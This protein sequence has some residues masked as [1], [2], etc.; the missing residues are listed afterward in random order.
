MSQTLFLNLAALASLVPASLLPF[1]DGGRRDRLFWLLLA[2]AIIGSIGWTA[3]QVAETWNTSLS[4]DLWVGISASLVLFAI[5]AGLN[6]HAWRLTPLLLPYMGLLGLLALVFQSPERT[7]SGLAPA[8][9]VI[10]HIISSVAT[11]GFLTLAA[12]AALAAFLQA[13]S[14][15]LKRPNSLTRS[16]P[17]LADSERLSEVLLAASE[18]VL[19]LGIASGMAMEYLETGNALIL[20]HKNILSLLAFLVIGVL[21]VGRRICGVRGQIAARVVL[22]AY[23]LLILGYFGVKFVR[24]VLLG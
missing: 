6:R 21:L 9:W 17:S 14:L 13:R 16:L 20:D 22:A 2:I 1:R 15:K 8:A 7:M 23:L 11:L 18:T 10:G 4:A 12:V 3:N 19:G 24:Q 5:T